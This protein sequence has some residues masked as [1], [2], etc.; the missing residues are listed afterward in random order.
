MFLSR[1]LR[2]VP[3]IFFLCIASGC[4]TVA[5]HTT[6]KTASTAFNKPETTYLGKT[7]AEIAASHGGES[8]FLLM[9]R[10]R[11]ALAWRAIL[12]DSAQKSIDAQYFLWK[13]DEAGKVMMQRL[14]SAADRGV[15]VRVMID[16][17]MTESD[18]EYLAMFGA[19]P[20][21][22]LRLYKPFGPKHKYLPG[23][24]LKYAVDMKV[25][26]HRMHNKLY[27]V[28]GSVA[29]VGGRNIGNE[30]F[31][32]PG[33]F[34]NRSRDLLALG[35]VLNTTGKAFDLYWNSDWTVPIEQVVT[36][37][38]GKEQIRAMRESL[39]KIAASPSSYPRGFH[40]EPKNIDAEMA[41]LEKKLL[42]GK[43]RL[44]VD[45]VPELNGK[46]QTHA[47]LDRTGVTLRRLSDGMRKEIYIQSAYLIMSESGIKAITTAKNKG[48]KVKL[49]TN[50]MATNNHLSAFVG[51]RKQRKKLLK[52][53]AELY[54][55]RPDA[56]SERA[57]FTEAELKKYK[58]FFGLHAKTAVFD[59]KY[60]FVGSY[61]LDP[62]SANLNTEMGLLVESEPLAKAVAES[63]ENDIAAGNSWQV[64]LKD[65]G[66]VEWITV[67]NG[68]V[69]SELEKEPMTSKGRRAE[70]D[71]LTIV[72]DDSQL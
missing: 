26:N 1:Y 50:S 39:N 20:N 4:S 28:D 37:L 31:E 14:L 48:V 56:K 57:L 35:P 45:A 41:E 27:I 72:P 21:I 42:W 2:L 11:D 68:E 5:S 43:A 49:A 47:E 46:P 62:R 66:S 17:S 18:P 9:D 44:L 6:D 59:R 19:H 58:T 3:V 29:I 16:D 70:A 53:G 40:D 33:P 67:E 51:Y 22:E 24:W 13:D 54:E 8:G 61:N 52:A 71:L 15:R 32:Y 34:V 30:Y 60:A 7:A 23:R 69:T 65:D 38:P 36:P 10:G 25:L 64:I 63:I 12:A 55:M